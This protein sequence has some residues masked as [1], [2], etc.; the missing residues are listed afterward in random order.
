MEL[1]PLIQRMDPTTAEAML[2]A[3]WSGPHGALS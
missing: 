2:A 1:E 3:V